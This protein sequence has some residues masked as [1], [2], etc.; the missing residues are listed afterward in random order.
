MTTM[1]TIKDLVEDWIVMRS[2]LVRQLE[3]LKTEQVHTGSDSSDA[4]EATIIRVEVCIAE[5]TSLLK[6]HVRA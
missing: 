4:A 3:T 1:V 2:T 5:L 6:E